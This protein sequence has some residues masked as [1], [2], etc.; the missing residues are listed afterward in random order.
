[1]GRVIAFPP[2]WSRNCLTFLQNARYQCRARSRISARVTTRWTRSR[3]TQPISIFRPTAHSHR[4]EQR[5]RD[6]ARGANV[7]LRDSRI[8]ASLPIEMARRAHRAERHRP[9]LW[10]EL[11]QRLRRADGRASDAISA[12]RPHGRY[13]A[14]IS[15]PA[16]VM[17]A[18]AARIDEAAIELIVDASEAERVAALAFATPRCERRGSASDIAADHN[19][20]RLR[21]LSDEVSRIAA[22]LARLSAGPAQPAPDLAPGR[23]RSA[24]IGR[25]SPVGNSRAAASRPLFRRRTVRRSCVGHAAGLAP[26]GD[27]A[28]PSAGI[29]PVHC[30]GCSRDD[31][32]ALA[33][34]DGEQGMFLRRADPHDGRRVFVELAPETSQALRRY[35]AE[36]GSD[37]RDL[38][39]ACGL[40]AAWHGAPAGG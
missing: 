26:G 2:L 19:A 33:Q 29:E 36:V 34:D 39:A 18:V 14:V 4:R 22:T 5:G 10:I 8:G 40:A 21:Q 31:R 27:C 24:A 7:P 1:M 28:A 15:T 37:R 23:G 30:R 3:A 32:A 11:D 17:D 35:F 6:G 9:A 12:R 16:G 25:D 13:A 38:S 20:D